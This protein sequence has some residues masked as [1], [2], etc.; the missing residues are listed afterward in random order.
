[1]SILY[2]FPEKY[3]FYLMKIPKRGCQ[4]FFGILLQLFGSISKTVSIRLST[5]VS[6]K[7]SY[8]SPSGKEELSSYYLLKKH[9]IMKK[10]IHTLALQSIKVKLLGLLLFLAGNLQACS[11]EGTASIQVNADV[12]YFNGT[13]ET[14]EL[15][16]ESSGEWTVTVAKGGEW[17]HYK[18]KENAPSVLSVSTDANQTGERTPDPVNHLFRLHRK[19]KS[20]NLSKGSLILHHPHLSASGFRSAS[21]F[22]NR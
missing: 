15:Q 14:Q 18:M 21:F 13:G 11:D 16:I 5:F 7:N 3:I 4:F 6:I 17:C 2:S 1:M 8:E 20:G 22:I 10:L 12:L 9:T 19:K